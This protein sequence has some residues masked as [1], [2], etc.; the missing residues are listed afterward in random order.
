MRR[1]ARPTRSTG[2]LLAI[3]VIVVLVGLTCGIVLSRLRPELA[4]DLRDSVL[5][6]IERLVHGRARPEI[7]VEG[8]RGEPAGLNP[9]LYGDAAG[10]QVTSL[11]FCG[12]TRVDGAGRVLP[13]LAESWEASA[14]GRIWRFSMRSDASWHDGRPVTPADVAFTVNS[15]ADVEFPSDLRG[16]WAGH[17][18]WQDGDWVVVVQLPEADPDFPI[19]ASVPVLPR[20]LLSPIALHQWYEDEFNR[21]PVGCGPYQF[22]DWVPGREI[23]L[24]ANQSYFLGAPS[25]PALVCRF[26]G[27]EQGDDASPSPG[28]APGLDGLAVTEM[29]GA[30]S[31][32]GGLCSPAAAAQLA[33]RRDLDLVRWPGAV[34]CVLVP[35]HR[36]VV[37]ADPAVR[38]A[39]DLALDRAALMSAVAGA[40]GISGQR[41]GGPSDQAGPY[42]FAGGP[43]IPGTAA[44]DGQP[45][46]FEFAPDLGAVTLEAAGWLDV[47]GDGVRERGGADLEVGLAYPAG[48]PD[49]A[50]AAQEIRAQMAD[51]G[52]RVVPGELGLTDYLALWGPP[53]GFDLL[54]VEWVNSPAPDVYDLFHSSRVPRAGAGGELR[55]GANIA[56]VDDPVLDEILTDLRAVPNTAD[57]ADDRHALH[58]S[59]NARLRETGPWVF[60]WREA[61]YYARPAGLEGPAPGPFGLYWNVQDWRW[62]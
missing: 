29:T 18:A 3:G 15:L 22:G 62:R 54:L 31:P 61:G 34:F 28:A 4:A 14:G 7:Y 55:G 42:S 45:E 44:A 48:R 11:I 33:V 39:M 9:L 20:H 56:A 16:E 1:K 32:D 13:G 26:F 2:A 46:N 57:T 8:I 53:F 43:F 37:G 59:L 6:A 51:I 36:R 40:T 10:Q 30:G 35:N 50:T 5:A 60:L 23:R 27:D 52:I 47:D 38:R 49:L 12:L 21:A 41:W 58:R 17:S 24:D 19:R 25:L